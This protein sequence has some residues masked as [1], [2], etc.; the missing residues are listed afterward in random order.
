MF[1]FLRD[2]MRETYL[3]MNGIEVDENSRKIKKTKKGEYVYV[4]DEDII[5]MKKKTKITFFVL[6][7][8]LLM[9]NVFGIFL[10][11]EMN[12][13]ITSVIKFVIQIIL[14]VITMVLLCRKNKTCE[15]ASII[16]MCCIALMY[17][18]PF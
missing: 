6:G 4:D 9:L 17:F 16:L 11:N 12:Y 18:L 8:F 7:A 2:T 3:E 5:L 15:I 14:T 10:S 1:D 13:G